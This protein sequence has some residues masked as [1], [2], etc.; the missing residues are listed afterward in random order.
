ML[1]LQLLG[2]PLTDHMA[3]GSQVPAIGPLAVSV[4]AANAEGCK[5]RFEFS[6]SLILAATEDIREDPPRLMLQRSPQ[7]PRVLLAAD[8]GPPLVQLR[9]LY[10]A[11]LHRGW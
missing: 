2:P 7:P 9:F 3:V 10:S 6:E 8:T 11:D 1:P 4:K 5:P